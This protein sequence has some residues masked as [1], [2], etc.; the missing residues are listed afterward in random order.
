MGLSA[1]DYIMEQQQCATPELRG[2]RSCVAADREERLV[3]GSSGK[4][5]SLA[6]SPSLFSY[7]LF[8]SKANLIQGEFS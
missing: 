3:G 2:D 6:L 4:T 7:T 5:R 1:R 8:N